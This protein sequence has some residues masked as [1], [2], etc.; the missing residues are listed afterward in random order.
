MSE[1][2]GKAKAEH[3]KM[4]ATKQEAEAARPAGEHKLRVYEIV[5][6]GQTI[7]FAWGFTGDAALAVAARAEGYSASVADPKAGGFAAA[8]LTPE[9]VA[10]MTDEELEALG[11]KRAGKGRGKK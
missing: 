2:N 5:R 10:Q 3:K 7:G 8:K 9:R 11:L 1:N 6:G 4:F